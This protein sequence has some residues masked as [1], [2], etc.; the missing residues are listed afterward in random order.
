MASESRTE[1][2]AL[3]K[4]LLE[5]LDLGR[6]GDWFARVLAERNGTAGPRHNYVF[7][8]LKRPANASLEEYVRVRMSC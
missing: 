2:R 6:K 4:A 8:T 5:A 1:R 3:A 7:M